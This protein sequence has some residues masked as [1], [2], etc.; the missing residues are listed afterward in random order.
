MAKIWGLDLKQIQWGK[1]K[2]SY[3]WNKEYH[4]R[5]TRFIIYQLAMILTVVS[6]SL[7][8]AALSDYNHQQKRLTHQNPNTSIHN[9]DFIGIASYNIFVGVYVATI[10]GSAFFFDL[11]WPERHESGAVKLA[12]KICS[13][14]ACAFT[15]SCA[16][17]YTYI[18]ATRKV[19]VFGPRVGKTGGPALRFRDNG[20]AVASVVL[21]WLGMVFTFVSTYLLWHSIAHID[22]YGPKSKHGRAGDDVVDGMGEKP[23]DRESSGSLNLDGE[24]VTRPGQTHA[25]PVVDGNNVA[26]VHHTPNA[27]V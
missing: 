11:F 24:T 26:D 1:F 17:A 6:E 15:L 21:L 19:G 8:T 18:V 25:K 9:N 7:G 4:M 5:R 27:I 10:F 2:N 12:W 16:L 13:L 14:L 23:V 3:M 20:R 22:A